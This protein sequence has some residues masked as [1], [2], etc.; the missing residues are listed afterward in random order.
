MYFVFGSL[1]RHPKCYDTGPRVVN[2]APIT[3]IIQESLMTI[4]LF[5]LEA[6]LVIP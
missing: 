3:I 6:T 2:Y 5:I 1:I 4:V